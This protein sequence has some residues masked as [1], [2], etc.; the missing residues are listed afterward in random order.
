MKAQRFLCLSM[1][2]NHKKK[3]SIVEMAI[4]RNNMFLDNISSNKV[5]LK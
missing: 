3:F 2:F 5:D 1:T 4:F